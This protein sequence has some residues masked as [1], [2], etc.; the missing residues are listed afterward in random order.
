MSSSACSQKLLQTGITGWIYLL[1]QYTVKKGF[2]FS[3]LQP[4]CH[5]P[6]SLWPEIIQQFLAR[7]SLD[8][9]IP[10]GDGKICNIFLQCIY[11]WNLE[12]LEICS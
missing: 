1:V 5:E 9:D 12:I 8:G 11:A 4:G 10:A 6:N 7:E 3:R 2:R